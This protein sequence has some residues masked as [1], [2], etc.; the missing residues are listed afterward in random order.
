MTDQIADTLDNLGQS[1]HQIEEHTFPDPLDADPRA[2]YNHW[3]EYGLLI[4][5]AMPH[6]QPPTLSTT[7][8]RPLIVSCKPPAPARRHRVR[9]VQLSN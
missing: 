6:R 2:A 1:L 7:V 9:A 5:S 4:S 8:T 3:L